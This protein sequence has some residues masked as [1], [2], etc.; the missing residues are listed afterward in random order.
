MRPRLVSQPSRLEGF[1]SPWRLAF[2]HFLHGMI[3][4]MVR[5]PSLEPLPCHTT[6]ESLVCMRGF[7]LLMYPDE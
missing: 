3:V 7:T 6:S 2:G 1:D 5:A 4:D